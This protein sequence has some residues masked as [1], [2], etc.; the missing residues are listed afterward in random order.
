MNDIGRIDGFN[1]RVY[2]ICIY[3][4]QLLTLVEPF[5]GNIVQKLP[6]GGLEFGEGPIDCLIREFKEELNAAITVRQPFYIQEHYVPTLAKNN[7]QIVMLYFLVEMSDISSLSILDS[8]IQK[9][10]WVPIS[11]HCPLS[12]PVDRI[13]YKKITELYLH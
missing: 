7:K 3:N 1:I 2:G 11:E 5:A 12:L 4:N 6:G 9:V 13:V 10:E 8:N